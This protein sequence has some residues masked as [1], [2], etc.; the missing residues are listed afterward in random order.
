MIKKLTVQN[1]ALIESLDID[2]PK[3]LTVITGETGAGK[4]ILL[5]ALSLLLGGKS[6]ISALSNDSKNCVVEGD[7]ETD[8]VEHILRRVVTPAGRSRFFVDDSPVTAAE[9]A[10]ISGAL[11]DV[12]AQNRQ[13]YLGDKV[14][15]TGV[16]DSFCSNSKLFSEYKIKYEKVAELKLSLEAL[17]KEVASFKADKEY[18]Q[19]QFYRLSDAN[20]QSG[21]IEALEAE[22]KLL[23]N[24]ESIKGALERALQAIDN[25]ENSVSQ[26]LKEGINALSK[27]H[28]LVPD[29]QSLSK[30]LESSRVEIRDIADELETLSQRVEVSPE[31]LEQIQERLS[32]LYSL[33]KR[34][35]AEDIDALIALRDS[36]EKKLSQGESGDENILKIEKELK[37]DLKELQSLA[38]SLSE[39]REKGA[40]KLSKVLEEE[41]KK[42]DL[43]NG[44]IEVTSYRTEELSPLGQD[45]VKFM[46][47]ANPGEKL[48]DIQKVASGGELSRVMLCLKKVLGEKENMPTMIFDEIDVGVSGKIADQMGE[49]LSKMGEKMQILAITH[50]P[51]VASKGATHL[52]VYKEIAE[53]G[54]AR[55]KL[56]FI[57]GKERVMEVARLLSGK[58]T[59]PEAVENAKVLLNFAART[60]NN[61]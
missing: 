37:A 17:K 31:R 35:D 46:F 54:K 47:S 14:F 45:E 5:G 23:A 20:L 6:D 25:E 16:L 26:S 1:Y 49:M 7:F 13:L 21:E 19:F 50:L 18:Q 43:K 41:I 60:G 58:T 9:I 38:D 51:Q 44:R 61:K 42:L 53:D 34:Y 59:S 56:K 2:F 8:G 36:L 3:G 32:L 10:K 48:I 40:V 57:E 12:H 4:S 29:T 24:A 28:D 30:R 27:V 52:L 22:E 33:L 39:K 11:I 55:T 15:Q